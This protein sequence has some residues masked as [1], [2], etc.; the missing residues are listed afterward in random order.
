MNG[1]AK[2]KPVLLLVVFSLLLTMFMSGGMFG[3]QGASAQSGDE[4]RF[5]QL[6]QQ[7]KDPANG[8]FSDEGIPYHAIETLMSEAPD[9]G[10]MTTSE[11]YSYWIWL[12]VLYG[13][14]TGDWEPLEEA[15][16]SMEQYIIPDPHE[17]PTIQ[18]Y[19]AS[20]PATYA[21]EH[22]YPDMYPSRLS[23]EVTTGADPL[24][25]ELLS[26]YNEDSMYLM[27]WLLDVDNWYNFGNLLSPGHT[28][29]Y[30]NTF[31]RGQQESVWETITHPSQDDFSFGS[32]DGGFVSLFTAEDGQ[33]APQWRY[34]AAP[35]ADARVV[36]V[37][38]LAQEFGYDNEEYLDKTRK[39]GDY[40][41]YSMYDKYFQEIGSA[42]DGNPTPGTNKSASHYLLSWYTAWGGGLPTDDNPWGANWA[43]KIGS[44]HVHQG[45]QNPVAAYALSRGDLVP[46]SPTAQ[47][48]WEESLLRTLEFFTWLQSDEGA[49]AGGAT[50]SVGGHYAPYDPN[51]STFYDMVYDEKPVYHD[52]PSNTWFGFQAWSMERVADFYRMLAESGETASE[53]FQMAK[54]VT[55][56]WVNW[57]LQY[58]FV[59]ERPVVDDEG[60]FLDPQGDRILIDSEPTVDTVPAPGE[61]WLLDG[62]DWEGMPENWNGFSNHDGNPNLHVIP[63][64]ASQDVGAL[65]SFVK[66]LVNYAAGTEAEQGSY[67][68]LGEDA[69]NVAAQLLNTAWQYNDGIGIV[70]QEERGDYWRYFDQ[71]IYIPDGWTGIYGQ[72]NELPGA[73]TVPSDS[74]R[75]G[76]G[77]YIS[78]HDLR[79]EIKNDPQWD[80]LENLYNSSFNPDTQEWE[81]GVPTF[82][83]HRFWSQV[84]MATAYAVYD[85]LIGDS[86]PSA[87]LAPSGLQASPGDEQV[88]LSWNAVSSADSY[89]VYRSTTSGGP[90]TEVADGLTDTSYMDNN[91]SNDTTYY[92]VITAANAYGESG[93]SAEVSATPGKLPAPGAFTLAGTAGDGRVE[94]SWTA[95]S[96]AFDYDVQRALAG[97]S[98]TTIASGVTDL[99]YTDTTVENGVAYDYRVVA[100]NFTGSTSSNTVTLTPEAS[101][102]P[103]DLV[104]EYK[105]A[106]TSAVHNSVRPHFNIVNNSNET[107]NMEDLTIRYWYTL[108]G[109]DSQQ[110]HCDYAWVGAGNVHGSFH[111]LDK[112]VDGAD[113]YLEL[114]FSSGAGSL[115]PGEESS[116]IQTRFNKVNWT[117]YNQAEHYSFDPTKTSFAPWEKVTLY[118]KGQLV[119]GVEPE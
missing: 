70:T 41:R 118:Y 26:T 90:Y 88:L 35:D 28:A 78:Y 77:V 95:S 98:F 2:Q 109:T 32:P 9:Y 85:R 12:E 49:I 53:E 23:Q 37:M 67:S 8:Y 43:W 107:L 115:G 5:I 106:E 38:H 97:S 119:W 51:V 50:N 81:D 54:Q 16:D 114:S 60:Y 18:H 110:F 96:A 101:D 99:T 1:L 55:E 93:Y 58:T 69:K 111:A 102:I 24:H 4:A 31:Q 65:G 92:Y 66:V 45:Y 30:V 29:A 80:Y 116:E 17:Q 7:L 64:G 34:T 40:L 57:A 94:L 44:S 33:T 61:F 83:Y 91:V 86:E 75:G 72:G 39:M 19:N 112:P 3:S 48:D 27:H 103:S 105:A 56:N 76:N 62:Q 10:H 117:S 47:S 74:E 22:P 13:A 21:P 89:S 84:D 46:D 68:D 63:Q 20:S 73:N 11:A 113:H 52:P 71:R 14:Y 100:N 108:D 59:D 15:W 42:S 87:P 36:Q 104:L 82:E 25:Q 79:P 6:Y